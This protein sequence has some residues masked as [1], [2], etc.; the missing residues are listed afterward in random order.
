MRLVASLRVSTAGQARDGYGLPSQRADIRTFAK[1]NGHRVVKW[2]TDGG[3][4][5]TLP[6]DARAGLAEALTLIRDG[7]ADGLIVGQLDRLSRLLVEQEA[8]LAYVWEMGGLAFSADT[9]EI[10]KDDPDDPMRTAIRQMR[11]VFSQLDRALINKRLNDGKR[12][13]RAAVGYCEGRT[14]YGWRSYKGKRT[15]V[16]AEQTALKRM[17]ELRAAGKST[18]QIAATLAV[19][20]H[21]TQR[22][23]QWSS[24]VVSRILARLEASQ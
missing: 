11:G 23:G 7:K 8:V 17:R 14:E 19:E 5:G 2:C 1:V 22:G 9:G 20:G 13:K 18:R 12:A 10:L 16:P 6:P 24:P 21:P 3:L 4:S 15:P